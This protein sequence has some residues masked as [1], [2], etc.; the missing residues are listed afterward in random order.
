MDTDLSGLHDRCNVFVV[1]GDPMRRDPPLFYYGLRSKPES[2]IISRLID[3]NRDP[4]CPCR[5][6]RKRDECLDYFRYGEK[7][8]DCNEGPV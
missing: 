5:V 2:N 8:R 6:C 4:G 3:G 1:G 7:I